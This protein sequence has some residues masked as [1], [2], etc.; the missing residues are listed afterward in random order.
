MSTCVRPPMSPR[1][2]VCTTRVDRTLCSLALTFR[3][4]FSARRRCVFSGIMCPRAQLIFHTFTVG[5]CLL[6]Q[7]TRC[8][9]RFD[10]IVLLVILMFLLYMSSHLSERRCCGHFVMI[11]GAVW[12]SSVELSL[13]QGAPALIEVAM[14]VLHIFGWWRSDHFETKSRWFT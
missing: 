2:F 13:R 3:L 11:S 9:D 14:C 5:R 10:A 6:S 12:Q 1:R 8:G 7:C 4:R